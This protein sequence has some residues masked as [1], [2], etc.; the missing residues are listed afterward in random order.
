MLGATV[1]RQPD[2]VLIQA[3]LRAFLAQQYAADG[4]TAAE[5][6]VTH[7]FDPPQRSVYRRALVRLTP[8]DGGQPL[9]GWLEA[10][11]GVDGLKH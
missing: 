3:D 2:E 4:I 7:C 8:A 9:L 11:R 10:N 1:D 6:D 5:I